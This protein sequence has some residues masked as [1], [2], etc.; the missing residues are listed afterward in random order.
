MEPEVPF[1]LDLLPLAGG[2]HWGPWCLLHSPHPHPT[3]TPP[4]QAWAVERKSPDRT[5]SAS[6]L[7]R[8]LAVWP[9]TST[10]TSLSLRQPAHQVICGA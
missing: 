8:L 2:C 3:Q 7:C 4:L 9:W 6:Q 10:F 5:G 1:L